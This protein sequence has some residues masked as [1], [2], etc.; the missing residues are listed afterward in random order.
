MACRLNSGHTI[1]GTETGLYYNAGMR[2]RNEVREETLINKSRFITCASPARSE[3]EARAYIAS[4]RHEYPDATHVCTAYITGK[5][6]E[7]QRS[8]DNGEPSG[9]AGIPILEAIRRSELTD[10]CV[11]VVRYFG[12]IKLGTGGLARAYGGCTQNLLQEAPKVRDI[13]M[14]VYSVR[15][16]Y[17][18]SGTIEGWIRRTCEIIDLQY[19]E[20]VTCIFTGTEKEIPERIRDLSKGTCTASLIREE[21][22]EVDV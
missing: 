18:L 2:L 11:A 21:L 20:A 8:S 13:T 3:E 4:V 17:E 15:Y 7:I 12:G 10:T 5:N 16:P 1:T 6:G 19:D 14:P 22:R 9:T